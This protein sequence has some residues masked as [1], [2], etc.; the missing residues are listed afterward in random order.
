M[1]PAEN[2]LYNLIN[3]MVNVYH[4]HSVICVIRGVV[5]PARII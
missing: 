4:V 3:A 1:A 2:V 5:P